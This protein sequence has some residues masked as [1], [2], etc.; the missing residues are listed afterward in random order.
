MTDEDHSIAHSLDNFVVTDAD[1]P[2]Q[3][4]N[5]QIASGQNYTVDKAVIEPDENY[6]GFLDVPILIQ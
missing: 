4:L 2:L 6:S 5:L 3:D 1:S